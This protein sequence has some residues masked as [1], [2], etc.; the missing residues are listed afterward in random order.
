M[1]TTIRLLTLVTVSSCHLLFCCLMVN[2]YIEGFFNIKILF[3]FTKINTD[4]GFVVKNH[5][6]LD[7]SQRNDGKD[8]NSIYTD[9]PPY[10][11]PYLETYRSYSTWNM[12]KERHNV[13]KTLTCILMKPSF[14]F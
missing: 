13:R 7:F 1:F 12:A 2:V 9:Y 8:P 11:D 5:L 10:P 4:K 14:R 6:I 3:P